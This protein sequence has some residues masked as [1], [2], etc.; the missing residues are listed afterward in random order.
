MKNMNILVALILTVL[1]L[2]GS[3]VAY[4]GTYVSDPVS[5]S[6]SKPAVQEQPE[7][8]ATPAPEVSETPAPSEEL[9]VEGV[10][11][12]EAVVTT[13]SENGTVNIRAAASLDAEIIG[14]LSS[15]DRV[16]VLGVEGD[17]TKVRADGV[18][19][20]IFSKY[21]QVNVPESASEAGET[22]EPVAAPASDR[23][24][25]IQAKRDGSGDLAIG[26]KI[27]LTATLSGYEGLDYEIQWQ[28][29]DS[30]SGAW[31]DIPG[32]NGITYTIE[33][34]EENY[35]HFYR[36]TAIINESAG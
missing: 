20:Y 36:A 26:D 23:S 6:I 7:A 15:N 22:V 11:E 29:T 16:A 18:V 30:S 31:S 21:L 14:Q 33:L 24:I 1:M 3:T 19:G 12:T 35:T 8:A 9:P 13:E 2:A 28:T 34:N 25:R 10:P 17:W 27:V 32:A 5:P 4:A